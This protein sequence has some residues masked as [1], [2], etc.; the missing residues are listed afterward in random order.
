MT[1]SW[2]LESVVAV[3]LVGAAFFAAGYVT[4]RWGEG[5]RE[6]RAEDREWDRAIERATALHERGMDYGQAV[7]VAETERTLRLMR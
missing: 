5:R 6:R 2:N 1:V 7:A 4:A 3:L